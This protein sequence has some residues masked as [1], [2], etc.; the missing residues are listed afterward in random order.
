MRQLSVTTLYQASSPPSFQYVGVALLS[1]VFI[2][3]GQSILVG[4]MRKRAQVKYPQSEAILLDSLRKI[5]KRFLVY[6]EA[7]HAETSRDA[8][9]FNCAQRKHDHDACIIVTLMNLH[10]TGA[11]QNTLENIPIVLVM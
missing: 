5:T 3:L 9:V 10:L 8:F 2:L 1:T 11:H 7:A 6:A 4:R